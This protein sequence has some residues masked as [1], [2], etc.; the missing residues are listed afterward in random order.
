MGQTDDL[1][2]TGGIAIQELADGAII[3]G[4]A[5]GEEA[6][7][8][9]RGED[10]F[11][12]G[13]A[14]THYHAPLANGLIVGDTVR[15]PMHHACFSLRTG[16]ALCAPALHPIAAWRVERVLDKI[17]VREKL[18]PPSQSIGSVVA[19]SDKGP[20]VDS[21]CRGRR[22]WVSRSGHA[23]ARGLFRSLDNG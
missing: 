9:R 5:G 23:A 17:F 21:H 6:L 3:R 18:K 4:R 15:C 22:G 1:D 11:A 2:F 10:D 16:E 14:C 12:I 7:L 20:N 8:V 19:P 13:A